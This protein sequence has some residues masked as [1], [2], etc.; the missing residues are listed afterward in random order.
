MCS[1]WYHRHLKH[2]K[3]FQYL[4]IFLLLLLVVRCSS[5]I[6]LIFYYSS[7]NHIVHEKKFYCKIKYMSLVAYKFEHYRR[8]YSVADFSRIDYIFLNKRNIK[9]QCVRIESLIFAMKM[10]CIDFHTHF[11]NF[12]NF[13]HGHRFSSRFSS[14]FGQIDGETTANIFI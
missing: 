7:S 10:L 4:I 5:S 14:S 13:N 12:H 6:D 8:H 1:N 11:V 9:I 3:H 2:Y